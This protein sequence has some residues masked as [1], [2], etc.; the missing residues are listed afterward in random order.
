MVKIEKTKEKQESG[1]TMMSTRQKQRDYLFDNYK[2]LLVLLV[3][4]GHFIE[5]SYKNNE[6]LGD[7]KWVIVSF[8]M[9]AFIFISGYFSK[10]ELPFGKLVQKLLVPYLVYEVIYYLLYVYVIDKPTELYLLHP[11]FSLWY[12]QALFIWR[13]ITPYVKKIPYHMIF[14]VAAGLLI[15]CSGISDNFLSIPRVLVFY[16][17]FLAGIHFEREK[18]IRFRNMKWQWI[19]GAGVAVW[20]GGFVLNIFP[21][22]YSPK[23]FYGRYNYEYLEQGM[24][25][26]M[27][28][29]LICYAIGFGMTF[30]LML[31]MSE[32]EAKVSYIGTRTMAVYLFHG[33][34][35]SFMKGT[36]GI[37]S[38]VNTLAES[39]ML[40]AFC[41]AITLL[42]S[43]RQFT[44]LTNAVA[45]IPLEKIGG[46]FIKA[47][48]NIKVTQQDLIFGK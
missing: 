16:P 20:I 10:R 34:I 25:E 40:L 19:A 39:A 32:K 29:R 2:A 31:L 17:F 22:N 27:L 42:F 48:G 13:L 6:L 15:G 3:V 45:S 21:T 9:P 1:V 43:A 30:G 23:I 46:S 12:I 33:L 47:L 36:S 24:V 35:Y 26:G 4:I 5:L 7:M 37:L 38:G 11:K 41:I 44:A 28:V 8:H 14:A 18:L